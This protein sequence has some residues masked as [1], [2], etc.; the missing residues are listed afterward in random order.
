[1]IVRPV[2]ASD[3]EAWADLRQALWPD[4]GRDELRSELERFFQGESPYI[5]A[6]FIAEDGA[7]LGF[8]ELNVR[9]YTEGCESSPVPH[10][11]G[12][13]VCAH[14][15]RH[16]VGSALMRAAESWARERGYRELTS[17]TTEDYPLSLSAHERNGFEIVERLIALRKT[18]T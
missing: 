5:T 10:I 18:L 7:A 3:M 8:I 9:A 12:W 11:E 2:K 13:Y 14:A 15:R 1:M 16:G 6:A 4:A 17:D